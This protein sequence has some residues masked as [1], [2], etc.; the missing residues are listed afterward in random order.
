MM[1]YDLLCTLQ[2]LVCIVGRD[3]DHSME[4]LI[5][6]VWLQAL[7]HIRGA[8]VLCCVVLLRLGRNGSEKRF[9]RI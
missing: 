9:G 1:I 2:H 8:D 3:S 5:D 7:L 4:T 6:V